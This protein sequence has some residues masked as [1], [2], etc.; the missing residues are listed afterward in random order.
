MES[1]YNDFSDKIPPSFDGVS[2]YSAY[3]EDVV[4]WTNLTSL[5]K[6]KHGPALIGRL[7]D[8]ARMAS[9]GLDIKD[10]CSEDGAQKL[11]DHLDK[12]FGTDNMSQL[13]HDLSAFFDYQWSS[14]MSVDQFVIGFHNR[15]NR[16]AALNLDS[17]VRGHILLRQTMLNTQEKNL[18]VSA[19]GGS[20]ELP[21][22][23]T[24]LRNAFRD[25]TAP[26]RHMV[27]SSQHNSRVPSHPRS[28]SPPVRHSRPSTRGYTPSIN[29]PVHQSH[30]QID[31]SSDSKPVFFTY[32]TSKGAEP[33]GAIVDSGATNSV[34]GKSTLDAAM[35]YLNLS[36]I[37]DS[38]IKQKEH[39]FGPS[40]TSLPSKF[41]VLM[42]FVCTGDRLK[43]YGNRDKLEFDIHFDVV[44]GDLPFLIGLP[45]LVSMRASLNFITGSLSIEFKSMRYSLKLQHQN[46]HFCLPMKPTVTFAGKARP[47]DKK[48]SPY[49]SYYCPSPPPKSGPPAEILRTSTPTTQL[50]TDQLRKFHLQLQHGSF[51][52]VKNYLKTANLWKDDMKPRLRSVLNNCPCVLEKPP[53]PR[54]TIS[55]RPPSLAQPGEV[56][57]DVVTFAGHLYL[58][59]IDRSTRWSEL[60]HLSSK[61]LDTQ[62][63]VFKSL[64][65]YRHGPPLSIRGDEEYKKPDFLTFC[66]SINTEF[67]DIAANHHEGNGVIERANRTVRMYFDRIRL[68]DKKSTVHDCVQ[69][70]TYAKNICRGQDS[71]SPYERLYGRMPHLFKDLPVA[72]ETLPKPELGDQS[73]PV[74][75]RRRVQAALKSQVRCP[76][77]PTVGQSVFFWRDG[78]KWLG[79]ATVTKVNKHNAI[80]NHNGYSKTADFSRIR[81]APN[82]MASTTPEPEPK[83]IDEESSDGPICSPQ[84]HH[85]PG[86]SSTKG[87]SSSSQAS[88]V[89]QDSPTLPSRPVNRLSKEAAACLQEAAHSLGPLPQTRTRSGAVPSSPTG[90]P[91]T[92]HTAYENSDD[93]DDADLCTYFTTNT[94]TALTDLERAQAYA[95]E[96]S[97]WDE[98]GAISIVDTSEIKPSSNV[99]GSHVVYK[100]KMDG[101]P[102]ARIVPWGHRDI[103]KGNIRCDAP[104][105]TLD[106]L[107]LLFS[108]SAEKKWLLGHMDV[109][110]AFLQAHGFERE[111]FVKPPREEC[112]P[113]KLWKLEA[114]AYGL[115]ES[116][117]L[118][119]LTSDSSLTK[120]FGLIRSKYD[121]T[122]YYSKNDSGM[123]DFLLVT[124][125]DDYIYTGETAQVEDFEKFLRSEYDVGSLSHKT[126]NVMGAEVSQ[127]DGFNIRLTI[128]SKLQTIVPDKNY[129][130]PDLPASPHQL[131]KFRSL[132]GKMLYIGRLADPVT[133]YHASH[134]ASKTS[135]LYTHHQNQLNAVLR[136]KEVKP[137]LT[138]LSSNDERYH[139]E[140][141]CDATTAPKGESKGR[142]GILIV[143]RCRSTIHPLLWRA[144]K[145]HRVSR[146]STTAE[147]LA[148]ADATS[149]LMFMRHLVGELMA[150]PLTELTTDSRSLYHL[151]TTTKE[152]E[153][154]INKVDLALIR[155]A[156]DNGELQVIRWSPGYCHIVDGITK[157]NKTTAA[158]LS[159]TLRDGRHDHHIECLSREAPVDSP[160]L[161][162][163]AAA[164]R[165]VGE[166]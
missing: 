134:F 7:R 62:I 160:P 113:G 64:Y 1:K 83:A 145:L 85:E 44:D 130:K 99:I 104:C 30:D 27:S 49:A 106:S 161:Q 63:A 68:A 112:A 78:K 40:S 146:S 153:E 84:P 82:V 86:A 53:A 4:L 152:P 159:K 26:S 102:K 80:L 155:E 97:T 72:A 57:I 14:S 12:S 166:A 67:V 39:R 117:R 45:T 144:K 133:L 41:A 116:G 81:A 114:A 138:F 119:Y 111:V 35:S 38:T 141:F 29:R 32:A 79:P 136:S 140:A 110:A 91:S 70:A 115:T 108:I 3:K 22:I 157:A 59:V 100:R 137:Q 151:S 121:P 58:H 90:E 101:R 21:Q 148:G 66:H 56:S 8:D 105:L 95:K 16:I 46:H 20:Y 71:I 19:A 15:Y 103:E 163:S 10:A 127:D 48:Q 124:Q 94:H 47:Y 143:R 131:T 125:V 6:S 156:F 5:P 17:N 33:S 164:S 132:I 24:A 93:E 2:S 60:G 128:D 42:P 150:P 154:S 77:R 123:L 165:L 158:L 25:S 13:D 52:Q 139:L 9:K 28:P 88:S 147:I 107:R 69:R 55:A 75:S 109:K 89:N 98:K 37:P 74:E 61:R 135:Q 23:T 73:L 36:K 96:R 43:Q 65:L 120:K 31:D 11:L 34:V 129:P 76:D 122:L 162:P 50:T 87:S 118:W 92:Q 126:F 149:C 54:P 51:T 18:I 142:M